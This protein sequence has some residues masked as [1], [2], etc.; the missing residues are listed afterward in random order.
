VLDVSA[1]GKTLSVSSVGMNATAQNA[2]IEYASGPQ[3]RTI[4]S[5]QIDGLNQ[6]LAFGPLANETFAAPFAVSATASSGLPVSFAAN[7]NCT[8][9]G[10]VVTITGAGS[11]TITA[12]QAGDSNYSPALDVSQTFSIT[13]APVTATAGSGTAIYD[14]FT[15]SPSGCVVTG[16]YVGSLVCVNSPAS[17]GP[18]PG[19]T[20]ISPI[21][22]R[23]TLSNFDITLVNGSYTVGS[24]KASTQ[25]IRTELNEA[26]AT[27][28]KVKDIER[29]R[30]AIRKLDETLNPGPWT[31]DGNH[32]ACEHGAKVF[33]GDQ[34]AVKKLIEMIRDTS[35]GI[36]DATIQRWIN[37]LVAIDRNLAQT[38]ITEA[39]VPGASPR[40]MPTLWKS[41]LRVTQTRLAVITTKRSST[42]S[43]LGRE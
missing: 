2:G 18:A 34:G 21:V 15:K 12:S 38:A 43:G 23:D 32:V 36:P 25:A 5:F 17:G 1:N 42:V 8:V 26:L 33:N 40:K 28:R 31:P 4:F 27:A 13:R 29:L 6:T 35:P 7:G 16:A 30:E 39:N 10:A 22:S 24:L 3:A 20:L 9:T 19:T 14:G 37:I 11:C 41:W